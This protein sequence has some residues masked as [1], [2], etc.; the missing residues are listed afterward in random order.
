MYTSN[1]FSFFGHIYPGKTLKALKWSLCFLLLSISLAKGQDANKYFQIY[2]DTLQKRIPTELLPVVLNTLKHYPELDTVPIDF[3]I[4]NN[5]HNSFMQAK[6]HTFSMLKKRKYRTYK[7]QLMS[8]LMI[9]DSIIPTHLL[10]NDALMG[11]FGH[12]IAHIVDYEAM[13][14][15]EIML[16]GLCY[17]FSEKYVI[18][19]EERVDLIAIGHGLGK[20]NMAWKEFVLNQTLLPKAYLDK[21]KKIYMP[22]S[23][24]NEI[25][26]GREKD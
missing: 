22:P 1:G 4:D 26:Q 20:E 17:V 13:D 25:L 18:N 7:I 8:S 24:V 3:V 21:I 10:P 9:G 15:I 19:T 5:I 14:N 11:W 16:L 6:P 2:T 12:E 23:R